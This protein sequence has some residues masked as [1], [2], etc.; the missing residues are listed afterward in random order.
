MLLVLLRRTG[1]L[2]RRWDGFFDVPPPSAYGE[3]ADAVLESLDAQLR[4]RELGKSESLAR[5]LWEEP[6]SVGQVDVEVFPQALVRRRPVIGKSSMPLRLHY[7]WTK[8]SGG[9]YQV[10]LPRFSW[11]YVLEDLDIAADGQGTT[12]VG[13]G[14]HGKA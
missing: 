2:M 5:Y 4:E 13:A 11:W 1:I 6:F 3:S 9:G 10:M 14:L 8:L 12:A 7:A